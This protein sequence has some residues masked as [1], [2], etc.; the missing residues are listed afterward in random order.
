MKSYYNDGNIYPPLYY[1]RDKEKN[2][3]DII[4][5]EGGK[6]YPVEIKTTTDP[7][8]RMT[9]VFTVLDK[10]PDKTIADGA[11]ICLVKDALPI[12]KKIMTIPVDMI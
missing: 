2:E 11:I 4:I 8:K 3:I 12:G 7:N 9:E 1:Y 10:I 5:E 6:L